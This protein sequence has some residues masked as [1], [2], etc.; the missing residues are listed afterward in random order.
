MLG[1]YT[2]ARLVRNGEMNGVSGLQQLK[3]RSALVKVFRS[4]VKP[5]EWPRLVSD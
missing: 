4:G 2:D 1:V 3:M 5:Q